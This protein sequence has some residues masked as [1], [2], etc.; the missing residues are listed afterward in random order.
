MATKAELDKCL[1]CAHSFK[2]RYQRLRCKK[3]P[4][5]GNPTEDKDYYSCSTVLDEY[6]DCLHN[7]MFE[8]K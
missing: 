5:Y 3:F 6:T 2:D 8:Q 1:E 7:K 4:L